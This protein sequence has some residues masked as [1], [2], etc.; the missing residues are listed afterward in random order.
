MTWKR[1]KRC[2]SACGSSRVLISGR[3]FIVSM[4]TNSEKKS[5][6]WEIW[7]PPSPGVFA[8]PA[9]LARTRVE[10]AR[11]QER[12]HGEDEAYHGITRGMR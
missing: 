6:R 3:R 2:G 1:R 4:L 7:K 10:L 8:F 5:A 9:D 11:D 12:R